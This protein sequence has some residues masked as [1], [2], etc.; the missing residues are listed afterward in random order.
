MQNFRI[1]DIHNHIYKAKIA[2]KAVAAIGSFYDIPMGAGG[3]PEE[4]LVDMQTVG[5]YKAVVHSAATRPAQVQSINNFIFEEMNKH[6]EFIGFGTLHPD[7]ENLSDE[8]ERMLQMGFKGIKLHPD[9]QE[10]DIDSPAAIN[11][12]E[13]LTDRFIILFHTGDPTRTYSQP[14]KLA[15]VLEIFPDMKI[16]AAH[17]GGYSAWEDARK[18]LYGKNVYLDTSSTLFSFTPE[19]AADMIR[20]H[21]IDKVLYGTDYPMWTHKDE[22]KRF[23]AIPLTDNERNAILYE[24][25]AKL[26]QIN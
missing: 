4:L 22:L 11:M 14:Q 12:Y 9:F 21:G 17:M 2:D 13:M 7:M 1:I 5:I 24:N 3:T 6:P 23:M 19:E 15:K 26:L 8:I 18:Y 10:F 16:I 20:S 25:A